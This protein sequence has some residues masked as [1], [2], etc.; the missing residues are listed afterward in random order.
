MFSWFRKRKEREKQELKS[1]LR[2]VLQDF[3]PSVEISTTTKKDLRISEAPFIPSTIE[4]VNDLNLELEVETSQV[5]SISSLKE[6][7]KAVKKESSAL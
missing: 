7:L 1:L 2:E 6:K 5:G 3:K 4:K